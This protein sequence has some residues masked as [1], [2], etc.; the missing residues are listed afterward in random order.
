MQQLSGGKLL[1]RGSDE[2]L[3]VSS[4]DFLDWKRRNLHKL[5]SRSVPRV[6]WTD[7]LQRHMSSRNLQSGRSWRVYWLSGG[8]L[9]GI[10][11]T[12]QLQRDMSS[13]SIQF[14]RVGRMH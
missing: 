2:L 13:R 14:S 9:S 11:W 6:N 7:Q 1:P 3:W 5:S 10:I 4:R 8:S 12:D